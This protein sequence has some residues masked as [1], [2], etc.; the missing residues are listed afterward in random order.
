M[1]ARG[2]FTKRDGTHNEERRGM[3]KYIHMI[4]A[5]EE[6]EK[7]RKRPKGVENKLAETIA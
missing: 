6:K 3:S 1:R 7:N 4:P 5:S 2:C